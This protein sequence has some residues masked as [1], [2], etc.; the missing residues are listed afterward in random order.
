[1]KAKSNGIKWKAGHMKAPTNDWGYNSRIMHGDWWIITVPNDQITGHFSVNWPPSI[2]TVNPNATM[3]TVTVINN[4]TAD[5][6]RIYQFLFRFDP[7]LNNSAINGN[8]VTMKSTILASSL[9]YL[10]IYIYIFFID[11]FHCDYRFLKILIVIIFIIN[12]L[13][14]FLV[15]LFADV[16]DFPDRASP[17]RDRGSHLRFWRFCSIPIRCN[18][19]G[20]VERAIGSGVCAEFPSHQFRWRLRARSFPSTLASDC[21]RL[22]RPLAVGFFHPF[23]NQF[24]TEFWL[25]LRHQS[26]L[27]PKISL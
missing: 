2:P 26:E 12:I 10:Y 19:C 15:W 1:M 5:Q 11:L 6:M 18:W 14:S 23:S 25:I 3:F 24:S 7:G 9:L 13:S 16:G 22:C 4:Q 17:P 20:A 21:G 27:I 8:R